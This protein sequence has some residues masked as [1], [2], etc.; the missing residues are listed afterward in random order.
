MWIC[1]NLESTVYYSYI[2]NE[3]THGLVL[4][5]KEIIYIKIYEK[6]QGNVLSYTIKKRGNSVG[7]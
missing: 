3:E 1:E 7:Q 6:P 2:A 5:K 4:T